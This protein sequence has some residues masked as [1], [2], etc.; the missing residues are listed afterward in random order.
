MSDG[1]CFLLEV[2]GERSETIEKASGFSDLT[3]LIV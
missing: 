3:A 2:I 1:F